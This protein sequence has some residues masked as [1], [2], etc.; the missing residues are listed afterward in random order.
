V[1][2]KFWSINSFWHLDIYFAA[3]TWP[4]TIFASK[5]TSSVFIPLLFTMLHFVLPLF[6]LMEEFWFFVL[7]RVGTTMK[8]MNQNELSVTQVRSTSEFQL[9]NRLLLVASKYTIPSYVD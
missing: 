1:A 9:I 7:S 6:I 4:P 5:S 3:S 8:F 2:L